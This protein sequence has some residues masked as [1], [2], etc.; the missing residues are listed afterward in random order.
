MTKQLLE[1][2]VST[3]IAVELMAEPG[4]DLG[5]LMTSV[6]HNDSVH[7]VTHKGIPV[8]V[9][10]SRGFVSRSRVTDLYGILRAYLRAFAVILSKEA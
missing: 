1:W 3:P 8:L 4:G 9:N 10:W 5:I 7:Q 2:S 6:Q